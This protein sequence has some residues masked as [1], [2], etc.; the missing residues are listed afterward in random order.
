MSRLV[1]WSLASPLADVWTVTCVMRTLYPSGVK[2]GVL[3]F[4]GNL[5]LMLD[6][7]DSCDI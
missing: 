3:Y 5:F 7:W 4:L 2:N 1:G 6:L